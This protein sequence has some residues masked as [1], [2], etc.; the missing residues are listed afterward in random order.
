MPYKIN[1]YD[2]DSAGNPSGAFSSKFLVQGMEPKR[3]V[4]GTIDLDEYETGGYDVSKIAGLFDGDYDLFVPPFGGYMFEHDKDNDKL[5]ARIASTAHTHSV[6]LEEGDGTGP[7]SATETKTASTPA[8]IVFGYLAAPTK[9]AT[10]YLSLK[11]EEAAAAVV[12]PWICGVDCS[13][14][15]LQVAVGT[16]PG[17]DKEYSL[18]L[19]V[20]GEASG[21]I[22]EIAGTDK[23]GSWTVDATP[24]VLEAGDALAFK[25]VNDDG[26]AADVSFTLVGVLSGTVPTVPKAD[27]NHAYGDLSSAVATGSGGTTGAATE[28]SNTTDL[29]AITGVPFFAWGR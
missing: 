8:N 6:A 7:A 1:F 29:S 10:K 4:I 5:L 12:A 2:E 15:S 9:S 23:T 18:E 27:H 16:A 17:A 28:V 26:N 25:S 24:V 13:V 14:T 22:A 3:F 20:N 21:A 11:G 19:Y